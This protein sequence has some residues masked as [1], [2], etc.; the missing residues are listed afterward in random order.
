MKCRD[1][2]PLISKDK[3]IKDSSIYPIIFSNFEV[4]YLFFMTSM[5]RK[6]IKADKK[7]LKVYEKGIEMIEKEFDILRIVFKSRTVRC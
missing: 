3:A 4:V 6:C 7:L 5:F 1:G 2:N